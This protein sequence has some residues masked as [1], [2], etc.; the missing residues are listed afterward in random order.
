ML[1]QIK[2][3]GGILGAKTAFSSF[4]SVLKGD[5]LAQ[6]NRSEKFDGCLGFLVDWPFGFQKDKIC[7]GFTH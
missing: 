5:Q 2:W 4:D 7:L 3:V 1:M 6:N